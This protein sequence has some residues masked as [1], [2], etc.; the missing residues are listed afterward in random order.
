M[1][2]FITCPKTCIHF[3]LA[4]SFIKQQQQI[5]KASLVQT[6]YGKLSEFWI[7]SGQ[8]FRKPHLVD[9]K[10]YS[11]SFTKRGTCG[12]REGNSPSTLLP[13]GLHF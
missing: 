10:C 6:E 7:I 12:G 2:P 3:C 5:T 8:A 1:R 13:V 9:Y 4:S 11:A